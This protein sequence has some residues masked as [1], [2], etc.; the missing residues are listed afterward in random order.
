MIAGGVEVLTSVTDEEYHLGRCCLLS[1]VSFLGLLFERE[2]GG[3]LHGVMSQETELFIN[4]SF[5]FSCL[6]LCLGK[7]Y[8]IEIE[9]FL[10]LKYSVLLQLLTF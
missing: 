5:H 7:S 1:A 4:N 9:S 8:Y 2:D 10:Q 6:L 3:G